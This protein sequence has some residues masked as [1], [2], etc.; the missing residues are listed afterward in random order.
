MQ[1]CEDIVHVD[2]LSPEASTDQLPPRKEIRGKSS[3][4]A[5]TTDRIIE[6]CASTRSYAS[7]W[8]EVD[9][10]R[11]YRRRKSVG[12]A[13]LERNLCFVDTP[14]YGRGLSMAEG[15]EPVLHYIEKQLAKT[16]SF[17]DSTANEIVIMMAGEGGTQV[18]LVLYMASK[19][20]LQTASRSS[21]AKIIVQRSN[22]K[23]STSFGAYQQ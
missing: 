14:G 18:D 13:V 19:G 10:H 4:A 1:T 11:S 21:M 8:S 16:F 7:W 6:V 3:A 23:T 22:L 20:M 9:E 15:T 12:D 5:K 17:S 2:S